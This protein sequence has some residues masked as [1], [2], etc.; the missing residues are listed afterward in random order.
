MW[1]TPWSELPP[2]L[3]PSIPVRWQHQGTRG[4]GQSPCSASV[5]W[6]GA[7]S[8]SL[9][10]LGCSPRGQAESHL[11]EL[12]GPRAPQ[13]GAWTLCQKKPWDTEMTQDWATGEGAHASHWMLAAGPSMEGA[14]AKVLGW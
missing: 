2:P 6:P 1:V 8:V 7:F 14:R 12:H 4:L 11:P 10:V 3:S 9:A 13:R 5:T